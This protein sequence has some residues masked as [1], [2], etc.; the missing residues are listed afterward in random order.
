MIRNIVFDLGGVLVNWDPIHLYRKIFKDETSAVEFLGKVCTYEWNLEQDRGRTL[1]EATDIKIKEFPEYKKEIQAYYDR[2]PEMFYGTIDQNVQVMKDYLKSKNHRVYAL[3][4]WSRETFPIALE[5][6]PFF[7][8]FDGVVVSG[9]VGVIKPD[10]KIYQ[11]LLKKFGLKPEE[12]VFIDDRKENVD[13]A[14]QLRFHGI[15]YH[16]PSVSLREEL[17]LITSSK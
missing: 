3:T 12:S 10:P 5:L 4:N 6:F 17:E 15:H 1:K 7:G 9:E 14:I 16:H 13:A 8:D 11:L 2:W